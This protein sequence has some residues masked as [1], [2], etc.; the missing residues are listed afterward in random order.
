[1]VHV[2]NTDLQNELLSEKTLTELIDNN[3][4]ILQNKIKPDAINKFI[5]LLKEQHEKYVNILRAL[6]NCDG[7]AIINNQAEISKEEHGLLLTDEAENKV[8]LI[9]KERGEET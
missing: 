7:E 5:Y 9:L 3:E 2:M 8:L 6:V 1:M 4:L